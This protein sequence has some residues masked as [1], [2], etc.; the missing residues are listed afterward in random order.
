MSNLWYSTDT[1]S[2]K[3]GYASYSM[4]NITFINKKVCYVLRHFHSNGRMIDMSI[5]PK[6]YILLGMPLRA[7]KWIVVC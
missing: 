2:I 6:V 3:T 5:A 1:D 7:I 4:V